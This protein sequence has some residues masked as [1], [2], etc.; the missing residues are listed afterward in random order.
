MV[1]FAR[2]LIGG[3]QH[4]YAATTGGQGNGFPD[5]DDP[6]LET[7]DLGNPESG[8][9]NQGIEEME[10]ESPVDSQS[11]HGEDELSEESTDEDDYPDRVGTYMYFPQCNPCHRRDRA[12]KA[13]ATCD[14]DSLVVMDSEP[15][16]VARAI[17]VPSS[18]WE[19]SSLTWQGSANTRTRFN[20]K[21][22]RDFSPLLRGR[23]RS[24]YPLT[25]FRNVRLCKIHSLNGIVFHF[26]LY[27]L[28]R[29]FIG[30]KNYVPHQYLAVLNA[31]LNA[32]R[33][34]PDRFLD[35]HNA[36]SG[37]TARVFKNLLQGIQRFECRGSESKFTRQAMVSSQ[38]LDQYG[39]IFIHHFWEALHDIANG[40]NC[41]QDYVTLNFHGVKS[42]GPIMDA[43]EMT[44]IAGYICDHA[45]F[46][47]Q[48]V[49]FKSN[50]PNEMKYPRIVSLHCSRSMARYCKKAFKKSLEGV[51]GMLQYKCDNDTHFVE[52]DVAV[53]FRPTEW[54]MSFTLNG[55]AAARTVN[56]CCRQETDD[57]VSYENELGLADD[58]EFGKFPLMLNS[59]SMSIRLLNLSAFMMMRQ[60]RVHLGG[61]PTFRV[62]LQA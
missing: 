58:P 49:G 41:F 14:V 32:A 44:E 40:M 6:E 24:S 42:V 9:G 16:S 7:H 22:T 55:E 20:L 10:P 33:L 56:L 4:E 5:E 31:A 38:I 19:F 54:G 51:R 53:N 28:D 8:T 17:S 15:D 2:N 59:L 50:W 26:S 52:F 23:P 39:S 1:A 37:E 61:N 43:Q 48:A 30:D 29:R 36:L 34:V 46:V 3:G 60:L 12:V 45:F 21:K 27:L 18:T 11:D 35:C 62:R 47:A 25:A 13:E 57:E